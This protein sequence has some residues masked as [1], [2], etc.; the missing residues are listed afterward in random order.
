MVKKL[1]FPKIWSDT[2]TY[3][4]ISPFLFS[5]AAWFQQTRLCRPICS[6]YLGIPSLSEFVS[7]SSNASE[8][9]SGERILF[10]RRR[11]SSFI[12][13]R[14]MPR[15]VRFLQEEEE[16]RVVVRKVTCN[17]IF[18]RQ[19]GDAQRVHPP[20]LRLKYQ[21]LTRTR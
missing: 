6:Y 12:L 1:L 20:C 7:S 14:A 16:L 8:I 3:M 11:P 21:T 9:L 19:R 15:N 5:T 10:V 17:D 2:H 13:S 18:Q 4:P